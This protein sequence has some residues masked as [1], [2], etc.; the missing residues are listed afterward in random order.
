MFSCRQSVTGNFSSETREQIT[1]LHR[2]FKH[3]PSEKRVYVPGEVRLLGLLRQLQ[4]SGPCWSRWT[5][6]VRASLVNRLHRKRGSCRSA[7]L[8][9]R[10]GRY[11]RASLFG[12][13]ALSRC[14]LRNHNLTNNILFL[15]HEIVI[16]LNEC[17]DNGLSLQLKIFLL[18]LHTR[19]G[20]MV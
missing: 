6:H 4:H 7:Q 8:H 17:Y 13:N 1:E 15:K 2:R 9:K 16:L 19:I 3:N 10:Y 5:I 20:R 14:G 12:E 11:K 18:I